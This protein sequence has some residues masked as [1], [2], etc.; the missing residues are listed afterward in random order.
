MG[1]KHEAT[2][3]RKIFS[4]VLGA[5]LI[6]LSC[7][8]EA[9]QPK[10]VHRIGY[11]ANTEA[12]TA[13]D[14]KPLRERLRELGYV[15]GQNLRI[16]YRYFGSNVERLS[17]LA[18]ELVRLKPELIAV[19][20]NEAASAA[21]KATEVIP[22]VMVS[23][24]EAVRSGFVASL[25]HPGG[26]VT[27]LT[28]MGGDVLGKRLELLSEIISNFSRAGFLWSPSSPTAADNLKETESSARSLKIDLTSLETKDP[29][30]IDKV[31]QT[32]AAKRVQGVVVDGSAFFTAHQKQLI[33]LELKHRLPTM[34]PNPRFVDAGG[35]MT[36]GQ[37]R[38]EHYRRAA[39]I[40]DKVLKGIK[41]A[42]IPVERPTKLEFVINLKTAKQIGLTI[43]PNVLA[44]A[45]RVI[46]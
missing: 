17:E 43:P 29:A 30:D 41:P 18:A 35:L 27:G 21:T 20:G 32:A 33:A 39:E 37:D 10:K 40:I 46:R 7:P 6:A 9:Q 24:S 22:I 25:A 34:Y 38:K 5:L 3:R 8:A 16:E 28:S 4:F 14:I 12:T 11:L 26:N 15:E 1:M 36:Y 23:T 13:V 19:V 45:D 2:G 44:R 42:D 31:F